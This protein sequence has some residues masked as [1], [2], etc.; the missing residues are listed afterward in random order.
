MRERGYMHGD[1]PNSNNNT[2]NH[3]N[4]SFKERGKSLTWP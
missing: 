4:D 3:N 1:K 2:N